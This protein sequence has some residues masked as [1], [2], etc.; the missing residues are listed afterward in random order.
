MTPPKR[1]NWTSEETELFKKAYPNKTSNEMD[2]LFPQ[3]TKRQMKTKAVGLG[4]TK[5][6]EVAAQSRRE[7]LDNNGDIPWTDRE[8]RILI[9][10]FPHRGSGGVYELLEGN[11]TETVINKVAYRLGVSRRQKSLMWEQMDT[12]V[13]E[14]GTSVTITYKGW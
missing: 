4:L 8:K 3:Y 14:K 1:A 7:N 9:E 2:K 5:G 12:K 11:R 10:N 6:K 13:S